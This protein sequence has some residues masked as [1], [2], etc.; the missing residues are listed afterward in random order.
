[1]PT[2]QSTSTPTP[3]IFSPTTHLHLLPSL[4]ALHS[5]CI[6]SFPYTIATFLPPLDPSLI[7]R[8]WEARV[9]EVRDG[10]RIIIFVLSA[11]VDK[12]VGV[13][14]LSMPFAETGPFR[15][16]VEKLLVDPEARGRGIAKVL[17]SEL[18]RVARERGRTLLLLDTEKGSPAEIIYLRLGWTKIG[19]VPGYG[20]SPLDRTLKDGVFFYKDL[21][22]TT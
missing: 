18:E 12:V 2:P 11:A 21:N 3:I 10:R 15:A 6:T 14:M 16:S 5:T 7:T 20:I 1:M 8:W 17:M 19:E 13:V 4:A 9:D 22:A